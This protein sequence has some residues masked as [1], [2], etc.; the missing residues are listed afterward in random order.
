MHSEAVAAGHRRCTPSIELAV[1][2]S[3]LN[4]PAV[5]LRKPYLIVE[6]QFFAFSAHHEFRTR[7]NLH[8]IGM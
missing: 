5:S 6:N 1:T 4:F 8:R 2:S 3:K 7:S